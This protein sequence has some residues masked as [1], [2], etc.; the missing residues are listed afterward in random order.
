MP[1]FVLFD[2]DGTL[3]DPGGSGRMALNRALEDLAGI[4]D[5]FQGVHFA[6]K[7]DLQIIR[8]TLAKHGMRF[9]RALGAEFRS[10]YEDHLRRIVSQ[11]LGQVKPGVC[12]LLEA[13]Q[14]D[15]EFYLGLL[16]GNTEEGARIKLE[17]F[18]LNQ[19]FPVGAF[20]SD[21][22]DRNR[23]LPFAV[24]RLAHTTGISIDFA[25]CVVVGDTP[26]DVECAKV[27]GAHSIA[28]ATGPY[29][30]PALAET[31]ADLILDDLADAARILSW[32]RRDLRPAQ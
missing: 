1:R 24:R 6:G 23:L 11:G 14:T 4:N 3:I 2:I 21:E 20:G 28:V 16:T 10:L 26:K 9:N 8:E 19:Y 32:L 12:T 30:L 13:L 25:D 7:T 29:G 5:G 22:E 27:H 31:Q 15:S 18:S 17:P